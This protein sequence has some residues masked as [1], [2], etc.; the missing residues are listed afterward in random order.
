MLRFSRV[1]K[2]FFIGFNILCYRSSFQ[3]SNPLSEL[4]DDLAYFFLTKQKQ[5][6][7]VD[8]S[9]KKRKEKPYKTK[10]SNNSFLS[11]FPEPPPH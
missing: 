7:S 6:I 10:G 5:N 4:G 3:N 2:F 1:V 8:Y 9:K 11:K